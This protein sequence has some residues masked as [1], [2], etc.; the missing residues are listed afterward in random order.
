[1]IGIVASAARWSPRVLPVT[2]LIGAIIRLLDLQARC[3]M[4]VIKA[5]NISVWTVLRA[6]AIAVVIGAVLASVALDTM[7]VV[8]NRTLNLSL[9]KSGT[10][11]TLWLEQS[12]YGVDYILSA[13]HPHAGAVI[14]EDVT[15]F[16]TSSESG[17][18]THAKLVELQPGYWL[19][20]ESIVFAPDTPPRRL[21]DHELPTYTTQVDMAV[22]FANTS[23]LT[24]FEVFSALNSRVSDP[25][26]QNSLAIRMARLATSPLA[27]LG[28]LL[29]AFA[30]TASYRRTKKYGAAVLYGVVLGF[31][32]I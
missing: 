10:A 8:V 7:L 24:I 5:S 21:V 19:I 6:P 17:E 22:K 4:T 18:R 11:G 27:R 3:E 14:L 13:A 15:V 25:Q 23:D 26:L 29:I 16:V 32:V 30:F 20:P 12:R 9:P 1:V 2:L 31:V 28:L